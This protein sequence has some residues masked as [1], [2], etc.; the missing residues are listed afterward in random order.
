MR[1]LVLES[2]AHLKQIAD[3]QR[4]DLTLANAY[5]LPASDLENIKGYSHGLKKHAPPIQGKTDYTF[6][7]PSASLN[8]T[9]DSEIS[10]ALG[11]DKSSVSRMGAVHNISSGKIIFGE[12]DVLLTEGS[13]LI[14]ANSTMKALGLAKLNLFNVW[15][16]AAS[17]S[18]LWSA[19]FDTIV[20]HAILNIV[21]LFSLVLDCP[22]IRE[23]LHLDN[24]PKPTAVQT[25]SLFKVAIC[26]FDI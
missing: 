19:N 11:D 3:T 4:L 9:I 6:E 22:H 2:S 17:S 15:K 1:D 8:D 18:E 13:T 26:L 12:P 5:N 25:P 24:A 20:K 14:D 16:L 23:M 21:K 10:F 7:E